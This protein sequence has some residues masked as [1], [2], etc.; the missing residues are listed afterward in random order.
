VFENRVLTKRDEVTG[1][2]RRQHNEEFN[3]LYSSPNVIRVIKSRRMR[4]TGHVAGMR[5]REVECRVFVGI[6]EGKRPLERPKLRWEDGIKF[7]F[8]GVG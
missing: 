2:C 4:C 7:Y 3:D 8:H 5:K 1:D 6:L